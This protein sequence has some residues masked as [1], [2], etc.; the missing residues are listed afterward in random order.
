MGASAARTLTIVCPSSLAHFQPSPVVPLFGY[1]LPPTA[2]ITRD[3]IYLEFAHNTV[4]TD[5]V[6]ERN[7][8]YGLHFMTSDDCAYTRNTFRGNQAG[9]AVMYARRVEMT[10]NE[11][12]DNWG[13]SA[14]GLLLKDITDSSITGNGGG[15]IWA[16][17]S[18]QHGVSLLRST[19]C[20]PRTSELMSWS[21]GDGTG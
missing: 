1:E 14:F 7:L 21:A 11:F 9:V 2:K 20:R 12:V 3:G 8:R 18:S 5:N 4:V 16:R 15:G 19:V 13:A 17:S 6:S 10:H